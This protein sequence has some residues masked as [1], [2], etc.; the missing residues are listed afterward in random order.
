MSDSDKILF[1]N[2]AGK[3]SLVKKTSLNGKLAQQQHKDE[4]PQLWNKIKKSRK[5][6]T[7][8]ASEVRIERLKTLMANLPEGGAEQLRKLLADEGEGFV[9]R[10][11]ELVKIINPSEGGGASE[12]KG[13]DE[14][15]A[16]QLPRS[17]PI[18]PPRRSP[19]LRKAGAPDPPPLTRAESGAVSQ[20]GRSPSP[21]RTRP[22]RPRATKAGIGEPAEPEGAAA[23]AGAAA[24]GA[25]AEGAAAEGAAAEGR[26]AEG[27]AAEI[28]RAH[29]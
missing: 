7:M 28:G 16:G 17:S 8:P 10:H 20:L 2:K 27:R 14:A 22:Y 21:I 23:P 9:T 3:L 1:I 15:A 29:V 4:L 6:A 26:A 18:R 25:A 5:S 19:R 24:E 11:P 12:S 13:E